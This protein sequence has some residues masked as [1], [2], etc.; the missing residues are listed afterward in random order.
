MKEVLHWLIT[1][2]TDHNSKCSSYGEN[3]YELDGLRGVAVIIVLL[4][5]TASFGMYGQGSLG[6]LMFFFLSGF[7]LSLPFI[8]DPKKILNKNKISRYFFNR[9]IRI[10][11]AYWVALLVI[12]SITTV[13]FDWVLWNGSFIKGWNHFWSVAEE[14]R[15]Y[16]LFPVV[17]TLLSLLKSKMLQLVAL[18][19]LVFFFYQV[20]NVHKIDMID[21]RHVGFYFWVFLGGVFCCFLHKWHVIQN[22]FNQ[23]FAKQFLLTVGFT[24]LLLIIFSSNHYFDILWKPMFSFIPSGFKMNG[25]RFPLLWFVLFCGLFLAATVYRHSFL[26]KVLSNWFLRHIGLLSYSIYLYHM[27]VMFILQRKG[28]T[29]E[30][31][32]FTVFFGAYLAAYISYILIEK[33]ALSLKKLFNSKYYDNKLNI[34]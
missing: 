14:A 15:F 21:G 22:I 19:V 20:K 24:T 18:V 25:W 5:H 32:F 31:L 4:S 16:L 26:N 6:V 30:K 12:F 2:F 13:K 8:E 23:R 3:Y 17:I 33:P 10:L 7:V 9:L 1:P 11:P 27:N 28:F 29:G 34:L